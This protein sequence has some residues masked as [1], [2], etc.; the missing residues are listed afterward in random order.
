MEACRGKNLQGSPFKV[1]KKAVC[2]QTV[3]VE[4]TEPFSWVQHI[5]ACGPSRGTAA[6]PPKPAQDH[7]S[8]PGWRGEATLMETR[9]LHVNADCHNQQF[10][11]WQKCCRRWSRRMQSYSTCSQEYLK[12]HRPLNSKIHSLEKEWAHTFAPPEQLPIVHN[13]AIRTQ[14]KRGNKGNGEMIKN[15]LLRRKQF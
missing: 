13:K 5:L 6:T 8:R 14:K 4:L 7:P 1:E 2:M 12:G 10:F 15:T 11:T 3:C 9:G